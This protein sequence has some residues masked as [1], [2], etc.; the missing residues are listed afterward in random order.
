MAGLRIALGEALK[1]NATLR[2]R[3]LKV[4]LDGPDHTKILLGRTDIQ[5]ASVAAGG[6]QATVA[7]EGIEGEIERK[8][9]S[10]SIRGFRAPTFAVKKASYAFGAGTL[11]LPEEAAVKGLWLDQLVVDYEP[12]KEGEAGGADAKRKVKSVRIENLW[13]N[14]LTTGALVYEG[15]SATKDGK[16]VILKDTRVE[17]RKVKLGALRLN[18]LVHEGGLRALDMQLTDAS[19]T[20]LK[21]T[22]DK[23]DGDLLSQ[24]VIGDGKS[25]LNVGEITAHIDADRDGKAWSAEIGP[26]GLSDFPIKLLE[27]GKAGSDRGVTT[28]D[29]QKILSF[30]ASVEGDGDGFKVA[31]KTTTAPG[32]GVTFASSLTGAISKLLKMDVSLANFTELSFDNDMNLRKLHAPF[33]KID[34]PGGALTF[35]DPAHGLDVGIDHIT[36]RPFEVLL[37]KDGSIDEIT[38]DK[39]LA[40]GGV[41]KLLDTPPQPSTPAPGPGAPP[42]KL[43]FLST[44]DGQAK[45]AFN[46]IIN[47]G[48]LGAAQQNL[49]VPIRKGKVKVVKD[50]KEKLSGAVALF[51]IFR[52]QGKDI[53][54][55]FLKKLPM[56]KTTVDTDQEAD[57]FEKDGGLLHIKYLVDLVQKVTNAVDVLKKSAPPTPPG[58]TPEPPPADVPLD[59][60]KVDIQ[61][62]TSGVQ[63]EVGGAGWLTVGDPSGKSKE[64]VTAGVTGKPLTDAGATVSINLPSVSWEG[65]DGLTADTQTVKLQAVLKAVR[66]GALVELDINNLDVTDVVL[67]PA[68]PVEEP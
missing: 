37:R 59:S 7:G 21:A 42:M 22:L 63:T 23:K 48:D 58:Q 28:I 3:G 54:L 49:D 31:L 61:L 60:V 65:N 5:S 32:A 6:A 57:D 36:L 39:L 26:F 34:R 46:L 20:G 17:L 16:K 62:S 50:I 27:P 44:L 56:V 9:D 67:K 1:L 35:K 4:E 41:V 14:E 2:G 15:K 52:R 8:K 30:G 43:D 10:L 29:V 47:A 13:F 40:T 33:M 68:K 64:K 45:V 11:T 55:H 25:K 12:L 18:K 53:E 51:F 19:I 24:M 66:P 38:A